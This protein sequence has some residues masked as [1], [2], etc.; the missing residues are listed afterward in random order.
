MKIAITT[1]LVSAVIAL[2]LGAGLSGAKYTAGK[3]G[4]PAK[5]PSKVGA[6]A[7]WQPQV[8]ERWQI[9]LQDDIDVAGSVAPD[10]P[11][12]DID[13][14]TNT[15]DGEDADRVIG[16][17][18]GLGKKVICYFSAGT[19]EP[20]RP[21][22]HRYTD[23]DKGAAL[24]EWPEERWVDIRKDNVRSIIRGRIELAARM[25]CDGIDPD[26]MDGYVS[27][28]LRLHCSS[29]PDCTVNSH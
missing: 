15:D 6:R 1:M 25:G 17:L 3:I 5:G 8:G 22:S 2:Y 7:V 4:T 27:A 10:V 28:I 29:P 24:P 13:L 12:F 26:N 18:H 9:V 16:R 23:A 19:Y 20:Y 11:I 14:Y 21:D